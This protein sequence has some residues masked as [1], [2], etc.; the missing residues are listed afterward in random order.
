[1]YGMLASVGRALVSYTRELPM[2]THGDVGPLP[3]DVNVS[4]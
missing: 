2:V 4:R 1:M 3:V